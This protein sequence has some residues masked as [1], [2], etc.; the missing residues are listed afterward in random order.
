MSKSQLFFTHKKFLNM[1]FKLMPLGYWLTFSQ[2]QQT[3]LRFDPMLIIIIIIIIIFEK[4]THTHR[5]ERKGF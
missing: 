4:Q 2:I 3:P 5:G 1:F